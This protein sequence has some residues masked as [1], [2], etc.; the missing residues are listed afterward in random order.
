MPVSQ[1]FTS[2]QPPTKSFKA[3]S[4]INALSEQFE[5]VSQKKFTGQMIL[6][7]QGTLSLQWTLYFYLGRLIWATDQMHPLRRWY[8]QLAQHCPTLSIEP[9]DQV[10]NLPQHWNIAALARLVREGQIR[11]PEGEAIVIGHIV[12]IL[13]D[14]FQQWI[15]IRNCPALQMTYRYLHQDEIGLTLAAIPVDQVWLQATRDWQVWRRAGLAHYSPNLAPLLWKVESLRQKLSPMGYQNL[16]ALVDG[17]R[18]LRDLAVKSRQDLRLMTQ[19][20]LP[21]FHQGAIR[22]VRVKDVQSPLHPTATL[23]QLQASSA[24]SI[25]SVGPQST[26]PLIAHID[27]HI[28]QGKIMGHILATLQRHGAR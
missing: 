18:T 24:R 23:P 21:Y 11:Q 7:I 10:G 6:Q 27:D 20:I 22:L 16:A 19:S 5:I 9:F 4:S 12:E 28:L 2:I 8:R 14:I 26:H 15:Q 3:L 17:R 1:I 25:S 13:F